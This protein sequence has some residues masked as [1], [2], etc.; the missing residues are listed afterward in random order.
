MSITLYAKLDMTPGAVPTVVHRSQYDS[1]FTLVFSLYTRTGDFVIAS[2]TTARMRGTK[3]TGTGYSV[4]VTLDVSAK[5]VTVTGDQQMTAAAGSNIFEIVLYQGDLEICSSNFILQVERAAMDAD[6][7]TD[8]TVVPELEHLE[9]YTQQAAEQAARSASTYAESWA[10]GG[11]GT[12]EGEDTNNAKYWSEQA[13]S[14]VAGVTSFNG[15]TGAVVPESGDYTT[16]DITRSGSTLENSLV[17]I[18]SG[19]SSAVNALNGRI[20]TAE[21]IIT[22]QGTRLGTAE[23]DIDALEV[24]A[25]T[26]EGDIDALEGRATTVE[27]NITTLQNDKVDMTTPLLNFDDTATDPLTDDGALA[28]ALRALAILDDVTIADSNLLELKKLLTKLAVSL[29]SNSH[30]VI[31]FTPHLYDL[32][33]F[34]RSF[35]ANTGSLHRINEHLG[36]VRIFSDNLNLSGVST[37]LQIRNLP[38]QVNAILGGSIYIANTSGSGAGQTIQGLGSSIVYIRPNLKSSNFSDPTTTGWFT[39]CIFCYC[40]W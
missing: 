34:V 10:V 35:P 38:S 20:T 26:A 9:E 31:W 15:R 23:S 5:T 22:S 28:N 3:T 2:G 25:T 16:Q 40:I 33:T 27:S 8:E 32:D 7:I 11:T 12:R 24:R 21:G 39:A 29:E 1:D 19:V 14:A 13:Q 6:T 17:T 4:P 36:V 18:E 37:M 30:K